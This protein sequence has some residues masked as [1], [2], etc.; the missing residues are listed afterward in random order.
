M[1]K[2][3][4]ADWEFARNKID[5]TLKSGKAVFTKRDLA[6]VAGLTED[7]TY[8]T[9]DRYPELEEARLQLAKDIPNIAMQNIVNI[10]TD[11]NHPKQFEASKEIIKR[12]KTKLDDIAELAKD[13]GLALD[14]NQ[15]GKGGFTINF[16][17]V[18][19]EE[20]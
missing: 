2:I 7:R 8:R 19:H 3:S 10:L 14:F 15:D 11:E 18:E 5:K 17:K 4:E 20:E 12:Y 16:A 6:K 1:N 9:L 13:D